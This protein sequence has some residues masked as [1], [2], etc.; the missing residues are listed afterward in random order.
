MREVYCDKCGEKIDGETPR[1]I[2]ELKKGE[3][4]YA[5]DLCKKHKKEW[6]QRMEQL[7]KEFKNGKAK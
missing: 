2:F 4:R 1:V 5:L 7:I 3:V 6:V